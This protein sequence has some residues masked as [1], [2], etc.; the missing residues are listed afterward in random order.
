MGQGQSNTTTQCDVGHLNLA[1]NEFQ[2]ALD[3]SAFE[4]HMLSGVKSLRVSELRLN[5]T[6]ASHSDDVYTEKNPFENKYVRIEPGTKK[7]ASL[8][9]RE[10]GVF[11]LYKASRT[12]IKPILCN[13]GSNSSV[14]YINMILR[15][16]ELKKGLYKKLEDDMIIQTPES[17]LIVNLPDESTKPTLTFLADKSF[18]PTLLSFASRPLQ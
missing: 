9:V 4:F 7:E 11:Y 10:P 2:L 1:D 6:W 16:Q 3:A 14:L 12:S 18:D 15:R 5:G 8:T 13:N 17:I